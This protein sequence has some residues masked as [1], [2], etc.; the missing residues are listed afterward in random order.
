MTGMCPCCQRV[1]AVRLCADCEAIPTLNSFDGQPIDWRPIPYAHLPRVSVADTVRSA[2]SS[3]TC[4]GRLIPSLAFLCDG[5]VPMLVI[6]TNPYVT[7]DG[8]G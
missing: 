1:P 7:K 2:G 4:E 3:Q 8:G 6:R 5:S